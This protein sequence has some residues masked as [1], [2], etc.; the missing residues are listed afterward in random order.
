[1][2]NGAG[3]TTLLTLLAGLRRPSSGQVELFGE[4][5]RQVR[6]RRHLGTTPQQTALPPVLRVSEVIDLVG[7][8]FE[9]RV[10]TAELAEEFGLGDL[11]RRQ[12]G[13]LS[14]GQQRRLSVALAFV[15]RPRLVLLDEP[16]TGL[17]VDIRHVLWDAIRAFHA[18]GGTVLL[19]SHYLDEVEALAQRAVVIDHGRILA[20][21]SVDA[22]RALVGVHRV[23]LTAAALPP[24]P[25]VVATSES[26]GRF[27]VLT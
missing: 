10:P 26:D 16:T 5:P 4:N 13:A 3:K 18:E 27:D 21:D 11:L 6:S 2:P 12:A 15:G 1:G 19:T 23:S 14:G 7:A 17:D 24:L 9:D 22:I 8:H 25:N 20:D